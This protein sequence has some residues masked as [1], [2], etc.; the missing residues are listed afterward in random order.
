M[1]DWLL[2]LGVDLHAYVSSK[3]R[4]FPYESYEFIQK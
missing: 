3:N 4:L 1:P 2:G